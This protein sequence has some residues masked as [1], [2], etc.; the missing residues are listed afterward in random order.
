MTVICSIEGGQVTNMDDSGLVLR[1]P[2]GLVDDDKEAVAQRRDEEVKLA[3]AWQQLVTTA[4]A[5]QAKRDQDEAAFRRE[6]DEWRHLQIAL[7]QDDMYHKQTHDAR[8]RLLRPENQARY[9]QLCDDPRLHGKW[10]L[11]EQG[12]FTAELEVPSSAEVVFIPIKKQT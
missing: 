10:V 3:K 8:V 1:L 4:V 6:Q 2:G 9:L 12:R 7:M 11:L 5:W